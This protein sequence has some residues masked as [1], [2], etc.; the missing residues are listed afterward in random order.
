MI[1]TKDIPNTNIKPMDAISDVQLEKINRFTTTNYTREQLFTFEMLLIDDTMTRNFT[2]YPESFQRKML[3]KPIGGGNWIG[4][5]MLMGKH[6][7]HEAMASNQIGR[8]YDA[9]LVRTP[10]GRIGTMA[11]VYIP[12]NESTKTLIENIK[13][14]I[15]K[16]VSIGVSVEEPTCSI[17]GQ[18]IREC[19]HEPGDNYNGATCHIIMNGDVEG[20]EVSFVAVPGNLNA[21]VLTDKDGYVP[22]TEALGKFRK[23]IRK[24]NNS[25]AKRNKKL[26]S[27]ES[28]ELLKLAR[29]VE[30]SLAP[31]PD[32]TSGEARRFASMES[33]DDDEDEEDNDTYT[34]D[35]D[36]D[37]EY[38]EDYDDED[39]EDDEEYEEDASG[40]HIQHMANQKSPMSPIQSGDGRMAYSEAA[41]D[42][43]A[44][45][46][47]QGSGGYVVGVGGSA[48]SIRR[49][50]SGQANQ[51]YSGG[52]QADFRGNPV[53]TYSVRPTVYD[54]DADDE[55]YEDEYDDEDILSDDE[56]QEESLLGL[57]LAAG[58]G[59]L[60]GGHIASKAKSKESLHQ[61]NVY[62]SIE[63]SLKNI[64][65]ANERLQREAKDGR[66]Y[67]EQVLKETIRLGALAGV[68]P[69]E[70]KEM[71]RQ[72]FSKLTTDELT[73]M[74]KGYKKQVEK[75]Y[76]STGRAQVMA[77]SNKTNKKSNHKE[78][79]SVFDIV[80]EFNR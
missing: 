64:Y 20:Q 58:A 38:E 61:Q 55:D 3:K 36:E 2:L 40:L 16:E 52:A 30:G 21:K 24:E 32:P 7:D 23:S 48:D 59:A 26:V 35:D 31:T 39:D 41:S 79:M 71:F 11:S 75:L 29:F 74:Q 63:K 70:S 60:L 12:V 43:T 49:K 46:D 10:R 56:E 13:A 65:K 77:E 66:R 1:N 47:P 62:K 34:E 25:M 54:E 51:H 68:I 76:P 72:T 53:N 5:P 45:L 14:G 28:L 50:A 44:V 15:H 69:V 27:K 42:G 78:K 22:L 57:G 8:I 67:K 73:A 80:K 19:R 4:L 37:D 18:D 9:K 17:C 33:D 6:E